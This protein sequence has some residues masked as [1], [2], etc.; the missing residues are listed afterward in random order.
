MS[1]LKG[2]AVGLLS[3][4]LLLL[5]M[6][7]GL[8]LTL[9]MTV[10]SADFV[11]SKL[12]EL[13]MSSLVEEAISQQ[14]AGEELSEELRTALID[15]FPK[16]EPLVKEQITAA[17]Y[18]IFDYLKGK[19]PELN[20]ADTLY[21][22]IH[23]PDLATSLMEEVDIYFLVG[24]SIEDFIVEQVGEEVSEETAYLADYV[25][26]ALVRLKPWLEPWL[27]EQAYGAVQPAYDYIMGKN[28]GFELII[29]VE[30]LVEQLRDPLWE[31][32][33]ESPPPELAGLSE[34]EL[35]L[36]FNNVYHDIAGRIPS[37]LELS[38]DLLL[39]PE[40]PAQVAEALSEA[41]EGLKQ[42]REIIGYFQTGF[43]ILIIVIVLLM[44][45]II[46]IN[47]E[48]RGTSRILGITFLSYG[49]LE[50]IGIFIARNIAQSRIPWADMPTTLQT[51]LTQLID[52]FTTPIQI[53]SI[54]LI[55]V[56]AAL[57]GVSFIYKRHRSAAEP[58]PES[59][60]TT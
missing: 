8:A 12:N 53:L 44:A 49:M 20:L 37:T 19:S 15:G 52:S 23:I 17:I 3:S 11:T 28:Q 41:E 34:P 38:G 51:W 43:T 6:V 24:D 36:Y 35:G 45:G 7:F 32:F 9:N 10:L 31:S 59:P 56:G 33:R 29:P 40:I 58:E 50:L 46:L 57:L 21:D 48:V 18:P 54:I 1:P 55:V 2:T 47:R 26:D 30:Q 27:K 60:V 5:L 39:D 14:S 4:L 16:L 22:T 13:D 25:D 42:A